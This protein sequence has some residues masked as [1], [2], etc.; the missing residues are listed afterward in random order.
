[1]CAV[2]F[3]CLLRLPS[4]EKIPQTDSKCRRV[5]PQYVPKSEV[6]L[7]LN[8]HVA[9]IAG[10]ELQWEPKH[11]LFRGGPIS[12]ARA[13][14]QPRLPAFTAAAL[15]VRVRGWQIEAV[16]AVA[17]RVLELVNGSDDLLRLQVDDEDWTV[18]GVADDEVARVR[19]LR[20]GRAFAPAQRR[21]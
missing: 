15:G 18:H 16:V 19:L 8:C 13:T 20:L 6:R 11:C 10:R 7:R 4:L 5:R 21:R 12:P 2:A 17:L 14:V 3:V 1:M 9:L